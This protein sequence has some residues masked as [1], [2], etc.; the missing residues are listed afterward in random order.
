M[1]LIWASVPVLP[2]SLQLRRHA[3]AYFAEELELQVVRDARGW[4][5]RL[6]IWMR[7]ARPLSH[8]QLLILKIISNRLYWIHL[9][10]QFVIIGVL[11][12]I[13]GSYCHIR[14][15]IFF[16]CHRVGVF[17]GIC[18]NWFDISRTRSRGYTVSGKHINQAVFT[19][20]LDTRE[21]K[22]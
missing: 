8:K 21:R 1:R 16:R 10:L 11:I 22:R 15:F 2:L 4:L 20:D 18:A 19:Y 5:F 7:I 12:V 14:A 3:T 17:S 6:F 13:R 9:R